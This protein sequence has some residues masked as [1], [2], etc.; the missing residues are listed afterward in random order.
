[1]KPIFEEDSYDSP[2]D[3]LKRTNELRKGDPDEENPDDFDGVDW[4]ERNSGSH[5][6]DEISEEVEKIEREGLYTKDWE[7]V[8]WQYRESKD[9]T[10]EDCL[11]NLTGYKGHL[12][13][14]HI[15]H[16]KGNNEVGNL[17]ALCILCHAKHHSHLWSGI[18]VA[19]EQIVEQ[20]RPERPK[21]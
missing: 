2:D 4:A 14:H 8:S 20:S 1:M 13:V 5:I 6:Q 11:A 15:D 21:G 17:R 18:T 7:L 3:L 10:C 9:F 19:V 16:N 12:H